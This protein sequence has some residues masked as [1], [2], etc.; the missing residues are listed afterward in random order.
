VS[1]S[2]GTLWPSAGEIVG[3]DAVLAQFASIFDTFESGVVIAESFIECDPGVVVVPSRW[4]G[5]LR[6]SG[7]GVIEQRLAVVY[8]LRDGRIASIGYFQ[9]LD[10]A[11]EAAG[12]QPQAEAPTSARTR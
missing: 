9:G 3:R 5:T 6:G 7:A 12:S 4:R 8:G 11:L 10:E 2:A 1:A